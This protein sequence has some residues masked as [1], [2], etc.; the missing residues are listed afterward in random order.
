MIHIN[1]LPARAERRKELIRKQLSVAALTIIFTVIALGLLFYRAQ[2]RLKKTQ[3][4]LQRTEQKIKQLEPVIEKIELYKQQKEEISKKIAVII[5]LDRY[6]L[7][8]VV[9]L[10][11]LNRLRPEKLWFTTL[12]ESNQTLTISGV[13]IDNETIVSFLNNLKLSTALKKADL[14]LLRSQKIQ[15]LKLKE[16]TISCP[17]D[18]T[19]LPELLQK[20]AEAPET[21]QPKKVDPAAVNQKTTNR[22]EQDG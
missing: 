8:P 3:N 22:A 4:N 1:L 5:D 14:T 12:K 17:L 11:D 20:A 18:L 9:I 21:V 15:D 2:T 19:S 16:F 10:S 13:A 6:R 7:A